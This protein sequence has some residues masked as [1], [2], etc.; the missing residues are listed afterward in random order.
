MTD[1]FDAIVIGG[2]FYGLRIAL[3]L[4]TSCNMSSVLVLEKEPTLMNRA[5]YVNQARV[6]N[7]YHYP[8][9]VLTAY[10]SRVNRPDFLADYRSAIVDDF[11]H[12]YA[13]AARG[14]KVNARQFSLFC[15]R[16][17]AFAEPADPSISREFNSSM[18][19]R[20]FRVHEPAFDARILRDITLNSISDVGGITIV[21]DTEA[22]GIRRDADGLKVRHSNGEASCTAAFNATYS[23]MNALRTGS[24]LAPI[25]VQHELTEMALVALDSPFRER[26][27]TVMDGPFFSIM[28]FPDRA[29]H[30]LSHVRYTPHARWRENA[31][32]SEPL[33]PHKVLTDSPKSSNFSSMYADVVRYLPGLASMKYRDSIW[34][35]KTVLAK[36]DL[37]D[38]RPILFR[39]DPELRGVAT[40]MGGKID[41]IYDVLDELSEAYG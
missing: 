38:S 35:V 32:S 25:P 9:S 20:V 28:P 5:S 13:I 3:H 11:E 24:G 1:H 21:T 31:E 2:G 6:H 17:G 27:V 4:R 26:G 29:L 18:I 30:T 41:N 10:R 16:I 34:E 37:D 33:D 7:G 15:A 22:L 39:R 14:S 36:S 12:F 19:E 40:I 23:R 8:R